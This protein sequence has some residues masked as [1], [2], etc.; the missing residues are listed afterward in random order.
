[1]IQ[2]TDGQ[3]PRRGRRQRT[4]AA[5]AHALGRRWDEAAA[6][7]R[8]LLEENA[9]DVEAA[10]R[11][12]KALTELDDLEGAEQAYVAALAIDGANAIARKNL[13]RIRASRAVAEEKA[14]AKAKGK[15]AK[16]AAAK[17]GVRRGKATA[18]GGRSAIP[19]SIIEAAVSTAE[20]AL[21]RPV[22][23]ELRRLKS[24]DAVELA[25]TDSG[26]AVTTARGVVLGQIEPRA[27][28]RLRRMIEGGNRYTVIVRHITED[29]ATVHIRESYR[30]PS[31]VGQ[32]SFLPP[33][34]PRRS[35]PRA[36]SRPSALMR[37][38]ADPDPDDDDEGEEDVWRPRADAAKTAQDE[39]AA[40]GFS[41][42]RPGEAADDDDDE[43]Q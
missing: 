14:P 40:R 34:S 30:D 10:N 9:S 2:A 8:S 38:D 43:E 42:E 3:A 26:V 24:G 33:P 17:K 32:V 21:Q 1:M 37:H 12:G 7:N 25:A 31:L 6:E 5:I 22:K 18:A 11:L 16:A 39:L 35:A 4:E 20:F 28:L 41:E 23:A 36:Y 15:G 19:V 13:G 27:G 29:G